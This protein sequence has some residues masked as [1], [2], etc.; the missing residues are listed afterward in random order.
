[1][2]LG[3]NRSWIWLT[4]VMLLLACAA[5]TSP[6]GGGAPA[7][8]GET[9]QQAPKRIRIGILQ[10]PKGWMPWGGTSTAGG[11]QQPLWLTTRTLTIINGDGALRPVLAE[12]LPSIAAGTWKIESDGTMEQT[13]K[14]R[15]NAKWH[16]G[17]PVTANDFVFAR[18][19]IANPAIPTT[20]TDAR[21]LIIS[22]AAPSP[23][24]LVLRFKGTSP[25]AEQM[26]YDPYPQ[27]ILGDVYA[28]G[29]IDRFMAHEYWTTGYVGAAPIAWPNGSPA[30][31]SS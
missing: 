10:E 15:G 19:I 7:I 26:L 13:W 1:M 27:H 30:P 20:A 16:D 21:D 5:P 18:E 11:S 8:G 24:I 14:L 23:Q 6:Q 2:V 12:A 31:S 17:Q 9:R 4:L 25:L 28:T 3:K 22:A 29:D